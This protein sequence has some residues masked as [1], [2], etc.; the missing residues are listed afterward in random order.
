MRSTAEKIATWF[1]S[2]AACEYRCTELNFSQP[3]RM[4]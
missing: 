1:A 3:L 4:V 2:K